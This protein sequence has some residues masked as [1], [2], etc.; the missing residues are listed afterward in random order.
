MKQ[1]NITLSAIQA[2]QSGILK[3]NCERYANV[4][5]D[6]VGADID[7]VCST[8]LSQNNEYPDRGSRMEQ[9]RGS[10]DDC[11]LYFYVKQ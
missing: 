8:M 4:I 5:H 1:L 2:Q 9:L 6:T 10:F 3:T 7:F 11:Q